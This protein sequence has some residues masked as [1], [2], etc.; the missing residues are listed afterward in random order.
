[1]QLGTVIIQEVKPLAFY[2]QKLSKSQIDYT[3]TYKE[4]L[5]I[6]KTLK[7]SSWDTQLRCLGMTAPQL[8]LD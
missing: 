8:Q 2:S 1:M 5:I 4:I 3:M 7:V 6:V